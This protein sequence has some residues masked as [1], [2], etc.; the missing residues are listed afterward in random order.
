MSHW[1]TEGSCETGK[2]FCSQSRDI[3]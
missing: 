1:I 2:Y 3:S